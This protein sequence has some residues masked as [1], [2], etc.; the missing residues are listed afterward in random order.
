ME[1]IFAAGHLPAS[2]GRQA[3]QKVSFHFCEY[4]S[5]RHRI[6]LLAFA[7][8]NE[9]VGQ[10]HDDLRIFA[11]SE[12]LPLKNSVRMAGI[13]SAPRLPIAIA[14][15]HSARYRSK[16]QK[17]VR[18]ARP[19]VVIFDHTAMFQYAADLAGTALTVGS[20]HDILTQGWQRKVAGA[21]HPLARFL[22]GIESRRMRRWETRAF[23]E[24]DFIVPLSVKDKRLIEELQPKA[25]AIVVDAWFTPPACDVTAQREPGAIIFW[26]AMDRPENI[27]A[28]RWA[29]NEILPEIHR[30]VP[31]AKLYIAGNYG[32][33]L[34]SE[35]AGRED[36]VITGFVQDVG[37]LMSRMELALLPMRLGAGIKIKT[38]E[39]MAAG[40][41]VVTT[42]VG[43]EGI[44]G[45]HGAHYSVAE[46]ADD[47]ARYAILLLQSRSE[48]DEMGRR[49]REF[50][51][52][53]RSFSKSMNVLEHALIEAVA[54][55]PRRVLA[56]TS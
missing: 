33:R 49:A 17:L 8:D 3:G 38:L 55:R 28:V 21:R 14:V 56:E 11:S 29:A 4:L 9:L 1:I 27:D 18:E 46:T 6:H 12:L 19:D 39:C 54:P 32:E 7:A 51:L 30:S 44:S 15:R 2:Q 42:S 13:L 48:A 22:L 31:H 26:G 52:E 10:T 50:I 40:L 43:E 25:K 47:L 16:L 34:A 37:A 53:S 24:L 41:P 20:S 45:T 5:Q 35:F 23:A 36:I